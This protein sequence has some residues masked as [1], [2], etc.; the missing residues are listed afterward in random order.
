MC[1]IWVLL[2]DHKVDCES[3]AE[4]VVD[5]SDRSRDG[6]RGSLVKGARGGWGR[7]GLVIG[8]RSKSS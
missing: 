6:S 4:A 2:V 5:R 3:R 7:G 1:Q 8:S